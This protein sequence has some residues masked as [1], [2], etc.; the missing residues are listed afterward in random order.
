MVYYFLVGNLMLVGISL[1]IWDRYRTDLKLGECINALDGIK[2]RVVR[3][4]EYIT[5]IETELET[6]KIRNRELSRVI[7]EQ[8]NE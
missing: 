8:K 2:N 4:K 6:T 1:L 3:L 7:R 5:L